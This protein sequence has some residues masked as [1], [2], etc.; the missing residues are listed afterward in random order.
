[1]GIANI[2]GAITGAGVGE[3]VKSTGDVIDKLFTSD[4][5]KL[6]HAEIKQRLDQELPK[7]QVELNKIDASSD[8]FFN[9]GWR[10]S[11]GWTCSVCI[12]IY[13]VTQSLLIAFFYAVNS[14]HAGHMID[15]P[16]VKGLWDLTIA[17]LGMAGIRTFEKVKGVNK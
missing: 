9:S 3:V 10:P 7:L 17:M 15:Y 13:F 8:R 5:E 16:E 6:T 2:I 11:I 1:M 12:F 14:W 4:D